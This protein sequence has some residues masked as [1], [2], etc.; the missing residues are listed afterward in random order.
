MTTHCHNCGT[1]TDCH[2]HHVSFRTAGNMQNVLPLCPR[3][4]NKVH[5]NQIWAKQQ[6]LIDH[7]SRFKYERNYHNETS[8]NQTHLPPDAC[9]SPPERLDGCTE[10]AALPGNTEAPLVEEAF[11]EADSVG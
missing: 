2:Q 10:A 5:D 7:E 6:G 4:H 1:W 11:G 8:N 9:V 3:C